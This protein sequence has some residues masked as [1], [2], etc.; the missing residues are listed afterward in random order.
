[1][2]MDMTD[3]K[4]DCKHLDEGEKCSSF[5]GH[6]ALWNITNKNIDWFSNIYYLI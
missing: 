2:T 1:M 3:L 4:N 6:Y 5:A